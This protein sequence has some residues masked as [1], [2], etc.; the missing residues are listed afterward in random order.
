MI[1]CGGSERC[2]YLQVAVNLKKTRMKQFELTI[3]GQSRILLIVFMFPISLLTALFIGLEIN[4][5]ILNIIIPILFLGL[6]G[7]G[8][9]Y[10]SVGHLTVIQKEKRLEFTWSKKAIF[11]YND[12][13][14]IEID[15]IETLVIDQNELL[16]KIITHDRVVKINNG[17]IYKKDSAKFIDFLTKN[18][19]ARV[20]DSWDV[21]D[22]KGWL[23]TV[24]RI[25]TIILISFIGIVVIY[26]I[27]KGFNSRLLLF[28]PLLIS[29]LFLYQLQMKGKKKKKTNGNNKYTAF[30]R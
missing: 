13:P 27:L 11:K 4:I 19:N 3:F 21:W 16:K 12:I 1:R 6:V 2:L 8:L 24:Y 5:S 26:T 9:Y 14:P 23:K 29:Q 18:S 15:K 10:F 7:F 25:N 30:G 22:E 17:K 20:I 28:A